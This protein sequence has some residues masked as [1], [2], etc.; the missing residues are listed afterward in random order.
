MPILENP[1]Q[2]RKQYVLEGMGNTD[3]KTVI[4][5]FEPGQPD[6][7]PN[8]NVSMPLHGA[9]G[10]ERHFLNINNPASIA[11]PGHRP[12]FVDGLLESVIGGVKERWYDDGANGLE[13]EIEWP[14]APAELY[15]A[16][17]DVYAVEMDIVCSYGMQFRYQPATL[18]PD[19]IADNAVRPDNIKN[20]YAIFVNEHGHRKNLSGETAFNAR[21]G[22]VGHI[23]RS[24]AK[25]ATLDQT[26]CAQA[27]TPNPRAKGERP[28]AKWRIEIPGEWMRNAT[29]PVTLGPTIG[30]TTLGGTD[31][32]NLTQTV[33]IGNSGP[34]ENDTG[35][36][37]DIE[38]YSV[39]FSAAQSGSGGVE[40]A[41]HL[42]VS[43]TPGGNLTYVTS[44]N[45]VNVSPNYDGTNFTDFT[46]GSAVAMADGNKFYVSLYA[47][48][49]SN[50]PQT[51][52]AGAATGD[53]DRARK[54]GDFADSDITTPTWNTTD[55]AYSAYVT[56][57][58]ATSPPVTSNVAVDPTSQVQGGTVALS[59][60]GT[61]ADHTI[62]DAEYYIDSDPG[63]GSGTAMSLGAG[64]TTREA[65]ATIPGATT[66]GLSA[67]EHTVYVRMKD[68]TDGWG[69]PASTTLTIT[70]APAD[71]GDNSGLN[72][73]LGLS[74]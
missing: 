66:T 39:G 46:P 36:S 20:S 43:N 15:D 7:V 65:T 59:A 18:T 52:D 47:G 58:A 56:Y 35:S 10:L 25:D 62:T 41:L 50:T 30:Y 40:A 64:T 61:D 54:S 13:Y 74:L 1:G 11:P 6:F 8:I 72:L 44:S 29:F 23:K 57:T 45:V 22:K 63:A 73:G 69:D 17:N 33:C 68:A 70:E 2:I 51:Y 26:W 12:S 3:H 37:I 21:A 32:N 53:Y 48:V 19:E 38:K 5:G 4:G 55:R 67:G 28:T 9:T 24:F 14:S 42:P 34:L 16:D 31:A 49:G 71:G 60:D 27:I